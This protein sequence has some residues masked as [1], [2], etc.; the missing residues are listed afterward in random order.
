VRSNRPGPI[1]V[2]TETAF[3]GTFNFLTAVGTFGGVGVVL[4]IFPY[5]LP[6]V[7]S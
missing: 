2:F 4:C 1:V 7:R 6:S 3:S 5:L